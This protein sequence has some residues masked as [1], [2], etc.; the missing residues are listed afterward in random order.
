MAALLINAFVSYL[1]AT[2]IV[3]F[4]LLGNDTLNTSD[5]RPS[6]KLD[7]TRC[8]SSSLLVRWR[9]TTPHWNQPALQMQKQ[10]QD[11]LEAPDSGTH[12]FE[13][14]YLNNLKADCMTRQMK[15]NCL[16]PV[17]LLSSGIATI[18]W[19]VFTM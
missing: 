19:G 17:G 6:S 12:S 16:Y 15:S 13:A 4:L 14:Y 2:E 7:G 1:A 3:K 9:L 8:L 11:Y 18:G 10:V 5:R